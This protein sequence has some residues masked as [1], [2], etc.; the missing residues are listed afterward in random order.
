MTDYC[1][2]HGTGFEHICP[3]APTP[4]ELAD[5]AQEDATD[6]RESR[7]GSQAGS[8]APEPREALREPHSKPRVFA[9]R[10]L[11]GWGWTYR[12]RGCEPGELCGSWARAIGAALAHVADMHTPSPPLHQWIVLEPDVLDQLVG[13]L[14]RFGITYTERD[15][16]EVA[17]W[18]RHYRPIRPHQPF[19]DAVRNFKPHNS[20]PD[21]ASDIWAEALDRSMNG[22]KDS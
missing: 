6:A 20:D 5:M 19:I 4:A 21:P 10:R 14:D 18:E 1:R 7:S 2:P 3:H 15:L 11:R 16:D 9:I 12:C 13:V 22:S 17:F 8:P